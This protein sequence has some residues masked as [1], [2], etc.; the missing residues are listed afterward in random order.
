[1]RHIADVEQL[2]NE[3]TKMYESKEISKEEYLNILQGLEVE[4]SLT[5]GTEQMT[6]KQELQTAVQAAIT[7]VSLV[8]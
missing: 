6:K 1:M 7:A 3:A 8:A 4:Q 2:F 5:L